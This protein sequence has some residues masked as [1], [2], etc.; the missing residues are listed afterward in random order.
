MAIAFY[1]TIL[2]NETYYYIYDKIIFGS[3]LIDAT[4][5]SHL[6]LK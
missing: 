4:Y 1:L 3:L 2:I 5:F 6:K